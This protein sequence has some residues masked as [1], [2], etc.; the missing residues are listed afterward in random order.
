MKLSDIKI[1]KRLNYVMIL[2]FTA[3]MLIL[4][5]YTYFRNEQLILRNADERMFEEVE[6]LKEI[7]SNEVRQNQ[8]KV[9]ISIEL[10][11]EVLKNKGEITLKNNETVNFQAVNQISKAISNIDVSTWYIDGQQIQGD[12]EIVDEI[13]DKSVA[14]VTI[15]QRIPQGYLRISTNVMKL[16]NTR[17]TGTYIPYGSKVLETCE[18]GE[19]YYGRA[20]VVNDWY[21]TAYHP[22]YIDGKV[23]G[24]I[25]VGI[26][27]KKLN[28]LKEL[29]N[30]KSYYSN[31][32]PY[33]VH[34]DGDFIIH[35]THEG[36]SANGSSFFEQIL[37]SNEANGKSYYAWQ[38]NGED[39]M[40]YQYFT[41]IEEIE[42][43]VSATVYEDD[44]LGLV[45][46]LKTLT[47]VSGLFGILLFALISFFFSRPII[48]SLGK[49]IDFSTEIANGNLNA[50]LDIQQKDEIGMLAENL[51]AMAMNVRK[52]IENIKIGA[53]NISSASIQLSSSSQ[54]VSQGANEQ[55][56]STEEVSTSISGI[57]ESIQQNSKNSQKAESL[58][59]QAA[60]DI[61]AGS[62]AAS[63][64]VDAIQRIA[65][66]ISVITDIAFQTNILALNAAVEAAR[67][68]EHGKGFA[69]VAAE[70][71][72]LSER[73]KVAANEIIDITSSSVKMAE[74]SGKLLIDIIPNIQNASE[75]VQEIASASIEMN[76]S[77]YQVNESVHKL[78]GVTQSNAASS[79]EMAT[80][81]EELSSQA[82]QLMEIVGFFKVED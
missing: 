56:I 20:Y 79:E 9:N 55:A 5:M 48:R 27:E 33:M 46:R 68:G 57:T 37:S 12:F 64:T 3:V 11:K 52:T 32:Y 2:S 7:V 74:E 38:E 31:G 26:P 58:T 8:E 10:A 69:V 63:H 81:A 80:T 44:I 22:M 30:K 41:Y 36:S 43:Y 4:G 62:D 19:T 82:Q 77:A 54:N 21:L 73:T 35:P 49:A 53:E 34:K 24:I 42:S 17:A 39:K 23:E 18:R 15:F 78:N 6:N 16:D 28:D 29:F 76:S 51:Q 45:N 59:S 67:A 40:K 13:R 65:D 60:M 50:T 1:G 72:K 75:L 71:Q 66:I 61:E 25:Y 70:V 47:V 14:T